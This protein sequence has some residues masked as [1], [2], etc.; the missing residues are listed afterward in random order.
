MA[1]ETVS[2]GIALRPTLVATVIEDGAVL[3]DLESKYFYRVNATGWAILQLF[4]MQSTR[5]NDILA[6]CRRWGAE[7]ADEPAVHAFIKRCRDEGLVENAPAA[8]APP[9]HFT[10]EW[11]APVLERQQEPLQGIVTSAFDPSIPLAE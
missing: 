8:D 10:G 4:E 5:E 3:L 7:S 1:L 2:L 6:Q 9:V 11:V